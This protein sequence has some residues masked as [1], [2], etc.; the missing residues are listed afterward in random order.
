MDLLFSLL[1]AIP[2]ILVTAVIARWCASE[3]RSYFGAIIATRERPARQTSPVKLGLGLDEMS[4]A[5]WDF[6]PAMRA[7]R[8]KESD[9]DLDRRRRSAS[10]A[11]MAYL[12]QL[13]ASLVEV[14]AAA[15]VLRVMPIAPAL[16]AFLAWGL[17]QSV[18]FRYALAFSRP[19]VEE[20]RSEWGSGLGLVAVVVGVLLV[21]CFGLVALGLLVRG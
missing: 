21:V 10:V 2:A 1:A 8:A 17:M 16:V 4:V 13:P 18:A 12:G 5:T 15:L 11:T 9:P 14:A 20:L 6:L 7:L 3:Q 19:D